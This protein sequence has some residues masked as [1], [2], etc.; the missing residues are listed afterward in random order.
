MNDP[1]RQYVYAPKHNCVNHTVT[2]NCLNHTVTCNCLNHTVTC[3]CLNH[4]VTCNCLNHTVTCNCL[5]HT[6]TCNCLNHTVTCNTNSLNIPS[7][8]RILNHVIIRLLYIAINNYSIALL[9]KFISTSGL[10]Y[11]CPDSASIEVRVLHGGARLCSATLG[12]VE[13]V[14]IYSRFMRSD[15]T[16]VSQF[17]AL[18]AH[19]TLPSL[20]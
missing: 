6:V 4:T 20:T 7:V 9:M 14:A 2:C 13:G 17:L 1:F 16:V 10:N 3:N 12:R 5:N 15:H 19:Y 18:I 8:C 11:S